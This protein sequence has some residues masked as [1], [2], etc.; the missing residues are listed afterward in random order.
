MPA[1]PQPDVGLPRLGDSVVTLHIDT[2]PD[3]HLDSRVI[4]M[5]AAFVDA[6]RGNN[7][8]RVL[9][10]DPKRGVVEFVVV[11]QYVGKQ[12]HLRVLFEVRDW[13]AE[14]AS[15]LEGL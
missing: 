9:E 12:G 15:N 13:D 5:S 11:G 2:F 4:A 10:F 6:A 1:R 3:D 7:L 14:G 8:R